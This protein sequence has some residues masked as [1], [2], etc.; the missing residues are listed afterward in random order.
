[1]S[2]FTGLTVMA[3]GGGICGYHGTEKAL[4]FLEDT[5]GPGQ[6]VGVTAFHVAAGDVERRRTCLT[7]GWSWVAVFKT[8][9]S[10]I[11]QGFFCLFS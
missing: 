5:L 2:A 1:M 4:R 9:T 3:P 10:D 6:V 11:T 8:R 7:S